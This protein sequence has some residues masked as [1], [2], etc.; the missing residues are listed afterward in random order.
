MN[1]KKSV[2]NT[3]T[4]ALVME[5]R[6][7]RWLKSQGESYIM[8]SLIYGSKSNI[9]VLY[10]YYKCVCEQGDLTQGREHPC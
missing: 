9:T 4:R 7:Y 8:I 3:T 6:V 1:G 2:A 5:L 10:K